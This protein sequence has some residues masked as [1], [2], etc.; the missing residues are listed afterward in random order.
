MIIN[1]GMGASKAGKRG[2]RFRIT[3][4]LPPKLYEYVREAQ[5][6]K[7]GDMEKFTGSLWLSLGLN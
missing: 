6:W 4:N 3:I 7:L 1:T 2:K 5:P